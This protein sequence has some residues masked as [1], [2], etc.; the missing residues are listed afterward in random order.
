[1]LNNKQL[2]EKVEQ[3]IVICEWRAYQQ[4]SASANN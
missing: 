2:L 1:M 3:N 4:P